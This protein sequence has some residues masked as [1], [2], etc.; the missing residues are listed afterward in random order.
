MW[1]TV[2]AKDDDVVVDAVVSAAAR[3]LCLLSFV[4]EHPRVPPPY[5]V[6]YVC[7][8]WSPLKTSMLAVAGFFRVIGVWSYWS[9]IMISRLFFCAAPVDLGER[10]SIESLLQFVVCV[11]VACAN[12]SAGITARGSGFLLSLATAYGIDDTQIQ[13]AH[14]RAPELP[15]NL[16][17]GNTDLFDVVVRYHS[18]M[19]RP[20]LLSDR[21]M[22]ALSALLAY[23]PSCRHAEIQIAC[24]LWIQIVN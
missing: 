14:V 6:A 19:S 17:G 9:F 20:T 7:D 24:W 21:P 23:P 1:G 8:I 2:T 15:S 12:A 5:S 22:D 4:M 13:S 10:A 16:H 3:C 18:E 11:C